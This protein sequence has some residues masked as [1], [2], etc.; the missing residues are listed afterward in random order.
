MSFLSQ[1]LARAHYQCL[2]YA[3]TAQFNHSFLLAL[4]LKTKTHVMALLAA[5]WSKFSPNMIKTLILYRLPMESRL[6]IPVDTSTINGIT[7]CN[8]F[9]THKILSMKRK[10]RELWIYV[11]GTPNC[12]S[13]LLLGAW[14]S[15]GRAATISV[16]GDQLWDMISWDRSVSKSD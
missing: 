9:T 2:Q 6:G 4:A 7:K 3:I 13:Q 12:S 10:W 14:C 16:R 5:T 1:K 11:F 8:D 15:L